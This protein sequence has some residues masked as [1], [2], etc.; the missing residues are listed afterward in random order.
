MILTI[1][2][3]KNCDISL[4]FEHMATKIK[5]MHKLLHYQYTKL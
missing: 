2:I 4:N 5:E 3:Y 1:K